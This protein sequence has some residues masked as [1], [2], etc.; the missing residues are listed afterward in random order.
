MFVD[1]GR[2]DSPFRTTARIM[3]P[4][5]TTANL[6][7]PIV[8]Q[9]NLIASLETRV[10]GTKPQPH[11]GLTFAMKPQLLIPMPLLPQHPA[12]QDG[13]LAYCQRMGW[14]AKLVDKYD[15]SQDK[16]VQILRNPSSYSADP[17]L[18]PLCHQRSY[19]TPTEIPLAL[20]YTTT[21]YSSQPSSLDHC[22]NRKTLSSKLTSP[23]NG[24]ENKFTINSSKKHVE[25]RDTPL[26]LLVEEFLKTPEMEWFPHH[27]EPLPFDQWVKR[28]PKW[29]RK[30]LEIAKMKVD[31]VGITS[32]DARVRNFI[33]RETTHK[34]TD[35]RNISPRTDEFLVTVGPYISAIEK[36]AH[37]A[38]FLVK[39]M[40]LKM[41]AKKMDKLLGFGRYLEVDFT[42]FDKTISA[43]IIRIVEKYLLT[44][45]YSRDH[46]AYHQCMKQLTTTS[47]VSY[48]GTRYKVKGTR[49]S[50]DAH[51]SLGN[52]LINRF[53]IWLCLRKLPQ[54]AWDSMHEGDDGIIGVSLSYVNQAV[55][56][57]QFLAC[58]G[59][60]SKLKVCKSIEE[61]VFCGRRH[62]RTAKESATICDVIRTMRKFNTTCS[63]GPPDLLLYAK[64]LSYNYTDADTP[65]IGPVS[66]AVA[67]CLAHCNIKYSRKQFKRALKTAVLER[68]VL[69]DNIGSISYHRLLNAKPPDISPYLITASLMLNRPTSVQKLMQQ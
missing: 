69:N 64:A 20:H 68:W 4:N 26:R 23:P 63:L 50:G 41:R 12:N 48:F 7:V 29:R 62:V 31:K 17:A 27:L 11:P 5:L 59:F 58:L 61:V 39:G 22:V 49:C 1:C 8:C 30:Q 16:I 44:K 57:L 47:G 10:M 55:Y 54:N 34:F 19:W 15:P 52:G 45:P 53:I 25:P 3:M 2:V 32:K 60:E 9:E 28:Y 36:H 37:H 38:P 65:I 46:H 66:Y 56:N 51:T 24:L 6:S 33:K 43:D 18:A 67:R 42:R 21:L 13:L 14:T 40:G 35:P